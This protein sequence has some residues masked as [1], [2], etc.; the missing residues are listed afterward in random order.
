MRSNNYSLLI[1]AKCAVQYGI[2][3]SCGDLLFPAGVSPDF[4]VGY[5]SDLSTAISGVQSAPIAT[6]S[7]KAYKGLVKFQGQKY[8]HKFDW[9]VAF[10]A[11]GNMYWIH[12]GTVKLIPL[13]TQDDV[14]IQR[15]LQA[16]DAFIIWRNNNDQFLISGYGQGM[17]GMPGD[18]GTS[19]VAAADDVSDTV[20]LE[21]AEKTK[22]LRFDTGS[23]TANVT[24][25]DARVI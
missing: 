13:N 15:L 24:Y 25:L 12:R 9:P 11:G 5:T 10:G 19:G 23:V 17:K 3:L 16:Q 1:M 21:G 4:Y 20:I 18:V 6:L 14:E 7:F 8:A 2:D 22:P